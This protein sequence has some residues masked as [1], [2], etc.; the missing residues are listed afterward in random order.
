MGVKGFADQTGLSV[1]RA[2]FPTADRRPQPFGV[3]LLHL[4]LD[5]KQPGPAGDTKGLQGRRHR[6]TDGGIRP[7]G[8]RYHQV[9]G[10]RVQPPVDGLAGGVVGLEIDAAVGTGLLFRIAMLHPPLLSVSSGLPRTSAR[11]GQ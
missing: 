8:V 10:Q 11:F 2:G 7:A 9:G 6:Q 4:L 5:L 1:L 3:D